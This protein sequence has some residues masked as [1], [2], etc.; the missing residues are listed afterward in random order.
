[1]NCSI[2][3]LKLF[4]RGIKN[5]VI[6]FEV[7]SAVTLFCNI[8]IK[9]FT[10]PCNYTVHVRTENTFSSYFHVW[11][12]YPRKSVIYS[13]DYIHKVYCIHAYLSVSTHIKRSR[14]YIKEKVSYLLFDTNELRYCRLNVLVIYNKF[15]TIKNVYSGWA[16]NSVLK[17]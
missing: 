5:L 3:F 7:L 10:K 6:L 15:Y 11:K 4:N 12:S 8:I 17:A 16:M 2:K 14:F 13:P 1:M 9:F